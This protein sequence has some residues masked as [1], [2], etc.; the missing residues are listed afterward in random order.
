MGHVGVWDHFR[1]GGGGFCPKVRYVGQCILSHMGRGGG[2][3]RA[4]LLKTE[5]GYGTP[6]RWRVYTFYGNINLNL[7]SS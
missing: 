1:W 4:T 6:K 7:N 2:R 5:M 3:R